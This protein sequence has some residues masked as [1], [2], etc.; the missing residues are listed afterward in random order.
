MSKK[1]ILS[2]AIGTVLNAHTKEIYKGPYYIPKKAEKLLLQVRGSFDTQLTQ[3][4]TLHYS[5][6]IYFLR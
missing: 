1:S 6:D 2:A 4:I 5:T 3:Y